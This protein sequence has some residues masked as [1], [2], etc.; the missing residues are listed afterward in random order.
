MST[1]HKHLI[2]STFAYKTRLYVFRQPIVF[3]IKNEGSGGYLFENSNLSIRTQ[4]DTYKDAVLNTYA[5]FDGLWR[6]IVDRK[7]E[8]LDSVN[9]QVKSVLLSMIDTKQSLL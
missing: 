9:M 4:A 3:N 6:K 8:D 7:D 1:P 5:S 2:M